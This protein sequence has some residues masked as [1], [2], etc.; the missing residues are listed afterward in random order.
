[1]TKFRRNCKR[2][3]GRS[4]GAKRNQKQGILVACENFAAKIAPM[5]KGASSMKLF[6]SQ[7][8]PTVK[9]RACYEIGPFLQNHFA[10]LRPPSTKRTLGTRVPFRS[11]NPYFAAA[12]RLRNPP[13]PHFAAIT[14]S[15]KPFRSCEMALV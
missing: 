6:C 9:S 7:K 10:A 5:R 3:E 15:V 11:P 14:P 2:G 13:K 12:K 8:G 4:Q 1:M